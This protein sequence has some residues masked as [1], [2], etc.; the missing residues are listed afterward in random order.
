MP[1]A[2]QSQPYCCNAVVTLTNERVFTGEDSESVNKDGIHEQLSGRRGND[3]D[4]VPGC[5]GWLSSWTSRV[6][7]PRYQRRALQLE[8]IL[9]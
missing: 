9:N 5:V 2:I 6:P 4:M 7:P 8:T 3:A 1:Q